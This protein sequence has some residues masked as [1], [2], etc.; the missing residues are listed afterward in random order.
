MSFRRVV[1]A[2]AALSIVVSACAGTTATPSVA[3][4]PAASS[5]AS[6]A[7]S[8]AVVPACESSPATPATTPPWWRDAVFYEVFVR[9]FADSDG[10]GIGDLRGLTQLHL[11]FEPECSRAPTPG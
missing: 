3:T 10:D 8:A 11:E 2:L 5:A 4:S 7:P 6:A 1:A 9:S